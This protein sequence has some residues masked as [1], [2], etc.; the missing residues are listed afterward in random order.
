MVVTL[1][2]VTVTRN[3]QITI[4]KKVREAL[5]I[6]EGDRVTVRVEGGRAVLEK[7]EEAVW[8]DCTGF[9]PEDFDDVLKKL[10]M[11]SR[12]RFRRLGLIP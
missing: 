4:P 9:L 10:R 5:G 6:G 2:V 1:T 7:V 8:S 11:D 3:S 12:K